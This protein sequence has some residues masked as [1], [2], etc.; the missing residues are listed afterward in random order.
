MGLPKPKLLLAKY[1]TEIDGE[2]NDSFVLGEVYKSSI[3]VK[4]SKCN[5][6]N[7]R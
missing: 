5:F 7:I 6:L 4:F 3:L 1:D 2:K